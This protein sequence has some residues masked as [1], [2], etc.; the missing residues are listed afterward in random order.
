[1]TYN[2]TK[3]MIQGLMSELNRKRINLHSVLITVDGETKYEEYRAPFAPEKN[4]RMYSVTKSFVSM[5]IGCL[6]D[7]GKL[8]LDDPIVRYFPDKLPKEVPEE[9]QTQ[10]VR[11]MLMMNTCLA[12]VLYWFRPE[13]TDRTRLYFS[14]EPNHPA[15]TQF[16]YDSNGSYILGVLVERLSGMKLLDYMRLKFLDAIGGF[17]SA[18]ILETPDGTPWAD[19]GMLCTTR[20]LE[21]FAR[22]VMQGGTWE[23]KQLIS[24]AYVREA[25]SLLITNCQNGVEAYDTQGYGYQIWHT[26]QGGFFF[27]GMGGQYAICLPDKKLIFACTGDNQISHLYGDIIFDAFFRWLSPDETVTESPTEMCVQEGPVSSPFAEKIDGQWFEC[28]PND[29]GWTKFRIVFGE[30]GGTLEYVNAQGPKQL[31]FGLGKNAFGKFPQRGYS[32]QR[33]NV[34]DEASPFLYDCAVSGAWIE[35]RKL[36]LRVQIIDRY[37]GTVM[38][39]FGFRDERTAGVCLVKKAEDFLN[40]YEGWI[41]AYRKQ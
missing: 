39:T 19:S 21:R 32:D 33:G 34:H 15:G 23:G 18:E 11:N 2:L 12:D 28:K 31:P 27:Y 8:S 17:E 35:D 29:A 16:W 40:E 14:Y 25:T 20:A 1:M 4:H 10:T 37:F 6:L 24:E 13:I 36:F 22:F 9:M 41:A 26:K 5:A 30:D 38:M 7:E 3:E